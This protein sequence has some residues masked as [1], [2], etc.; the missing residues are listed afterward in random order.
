MN[1]KAS[2]TQV[3]EI[4]ELIVG[5]LASHPFQLEIMIRDMGH[6]SRIG[7]CAA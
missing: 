6:I 5:M 7:R 1:T 4:T 2:A 3:L